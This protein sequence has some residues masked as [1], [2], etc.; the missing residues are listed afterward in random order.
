[1]NKQ[2]AFF[3]RREGQ[4]LLLAGIASCAV[5]LRPYR[6]IL[7][8]VLFIDISILRGFCEF[9]E[10]DITFRTAVLGPAGSNDELDGHINGLTIPRS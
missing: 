9:L 3:L 4:R 2:E 1:L 10:G 8:D 6:L 5:L 7:P